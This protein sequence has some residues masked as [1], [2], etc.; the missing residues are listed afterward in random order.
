M[1][2]AAIF[3]GA[4]VCCALLQ[5]CG[6]GPVSSSDPARG[7]NAQTGSATGA[8]TTPPRDGTAG[9]DT[10]ASRSGDANA[11]A[12]TPPVAPTTADPTK[13]ACMITGGAGVSLVNDLEAKD[14]CLLNC[15]AQEVQ[16]PN[17]SC[18]WN[19][20]DITPTGACN[21]VGGAGAPIEN[22]TTSRGKCF[23]ACNDDAVA[24]P[25]LRCTWSNIDL[26]PTGACSIANGAGGQ[27]DKNDISH[28]DCLALCT[29]FAAADPKACTWNG[30]PL[31]A[32]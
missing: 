4:A 29:A 2:G 26:T 5:A 28:G 21:I 27:V 19:K 24:H 31:D 32:P 16:H 9:A 17:L 8:T 1:R 22:D 20:I 11:N 13:A 23:L 14:F 3:G 25:N 10:A 18:L 15:Q 30:A 7:A 12:K 6:D